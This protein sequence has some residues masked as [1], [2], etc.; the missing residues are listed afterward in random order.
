LVVLIPPFYILMNLLPQ[1]AE[2]AE[3][4]AVAIP[5]PTTILRAASI[6]GQMKEWKA[7]AAII[8]RGLQLF[9]ENLQLLQAQAELEGRSSTAIPNQHPLLRESLP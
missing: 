7:A 3:R 8:V 2:A 5:N 4:L 9:P 1:A 6:R